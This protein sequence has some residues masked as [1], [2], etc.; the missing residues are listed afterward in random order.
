VIF[1]TGILWD[2]TRMDIDTANGG[3]SKQKSS[4]NLTISVTTQVELTPFPQ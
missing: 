2:N 4:K 1:L 3:T